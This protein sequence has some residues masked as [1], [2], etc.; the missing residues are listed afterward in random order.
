MA[1]TW[2][3]PIKTYFTAYDIQHMKQVQPQIDLGDYTSVKDNA[4]LIYPRLADGTMPPGGWVD[5]WINNFKAWIEA[6]SPES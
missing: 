2:N 4:V 6:G 1:I 5:E 3:D